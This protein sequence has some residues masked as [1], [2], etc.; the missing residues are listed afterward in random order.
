MAGS[1]VPV[2]QLVCVSDTDSD[3]AKNWSYFGLTLRLVR[4]MIEELHNPNTDH[5]R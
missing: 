3:W 2:S 4:I 1:I 5:T